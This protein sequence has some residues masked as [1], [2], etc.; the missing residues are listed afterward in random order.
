MKETRRKRRRTT[1]GHKMQL[2][3]IAMLITGIFFVSGF[4][5]WAATIKVP[6]FSL[7]ET[8]KVSQ[9]T[10]LY[11]R[12]G[13]ILLYDVHRDVRRRVVSFDAS[14]PYI[15]NAAVAIEDE[16][17]YQHIGIKPEA[18]L[19]ALWVNFRSG[20]FSQGGSTITQQVIKNA[21]LS[22]EK[23]VTRKVKEWVL[24]IKLEQR[25]SKEEILGL[26]LNEAPYG[27]NVYGVEE[28]SMSFFGHHANELTLPE[29]AYLAAL[30]QSPTRLSPYG[31]NLE[32]LENRK[33]TVLKKML[34]LGSITQDEYAKAIAE[35]VKF[36]PQA[37]QGIR[38]PHF[39]MFIKEKL[40][41]KYGEDMVNEG[42]L[43]VITT[44]DMTMQEKAEMIVKKYVEQ[45]IKTYNAKN[46]A[47]VAI[48]PKTGQ[49][50]TMVGSRDYF[51]TANEGNFNVALAK[52]Q[53]GSSFKP[54]VY[55]AAFE[56]SYTPDTVVFD[57]P[58]EFSARCDPLGNPLGGGDKSLCYMPENYD[59][60]Y[61]GPINLRNA[62][63]QSINIPAV[64][65]LYLVGLDRAIEF[66]E[67]VGI[68]S[69]QDKE[70]YGLTLVL[71][72]GEVSLLEMTSA[73]GVF[74]NDGKRDPYTGIISVE[75]ASG[76]IIEEYEQNETQV[77]DPGV[78]RKISDVL[79]DNV[80]RTP[81]FGAQ[82][83]L[84][85]PDRQ[86]AVKT[87][88]TNDYRDAWIL[89]YTPSLVVGA[90]A[91][92][93]DN[94]PMENK[95]AGFI[96]APLWNAFLKEELR[97][98]PDEKFPT[99]QPTPKNLKPV[100]RGV[101]YGGETYTIDRMSGKRATVFTP[102]ELIEERVIPNPHEILYWVNKND[103]T[104]SPPENPYT[105]AQFLLWEI[106]MQT[107]LLNHGLPSQALGKIP[108][109]FDDLHRPEFAPSIV[110]LSPNAT[111]T[112]NHTQKLLVETRI[113]S[114]FTVEHV[115]FFVNGTFLGS[116]RSLPYTFAF[117]PRDIATTGRTNEL[118]VVV[119]DIVGNRNEKTLSFGTD[120]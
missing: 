50:L 61:R 86:V 80:A 65:M 88:T 31:N 6:D 110:I 87:G 84:D 74:A 37:E 107:W 19:R 28:A 20:G 67:R 35:K 77:M 14:S 36:I 63:A 42:G 39:V 3:V 25:L 32:L 83:Y 103:P 79:S 33:N 76:N 70:R 100:L 66:A 117:V 38:A 119:Y 2:V 7:F 9:S 54:F 105:D 99:S 12:T 62:L 104:G 29:A 108:E 59:G 15:K 10:K 112:Y 69:L 16:Q 85:F 97:L 23:T 71:G 116:T 60:Q 43:R 48:D 18:I 95:V 47:L 82:S 94:T 91:G 58:T 89:G 26:Y 78:A 45:N 92:N 106:P 46:A 11:D 72:G 27:G 30:P 113:Q 5:L 81:A 75:D 68:T 1:L 8:G 17:F 55:G 93:N 111:T 64:K 102:T 22:Q 90:W 40:V 101:W 120:L 118:R 49:I 114:P 44:L 57:V 98:L 13:K 73:Y 115:D 51:D 4:L 41:E 21:L 53:P 109:G 56:N 52:R 24:A 96:I 34:E